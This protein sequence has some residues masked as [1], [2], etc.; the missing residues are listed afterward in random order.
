M[1]KQVHSVESKTVSLTCCASF[2]VMVAILL[3]C[4]VF[5]F[6][7]S[8]DSFDNG[9]RM[10]RSVLKALCKCWEHNIHVWFSLTTTKS[11]VPF[12]DSVREIVV[13]AHRLSSGIFPVSC[14]VVDVIDDSNFLRLIV[15]TDR[16][17]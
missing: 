13:S 10:Y 8:V 1:V 4:T 3:F 17:C 12:S 9:Q 16:V 6:S 14:I 11:T 7:F 5:F 15:L 2:A